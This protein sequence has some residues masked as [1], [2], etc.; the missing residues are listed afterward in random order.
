[1]ETSGKKKLKVL[2]LED[3]TVLAEELKLSVEELGL[4]ATD[5]VKSYDEAIESVKNNPPDL[6]LCDI[7]IRGQIDGVDT[8]R[9]IRNIKEIPIIFT[10]AYLESQYVMQA[11]EMDAVNYLSKPVKPEELKKY[12]DKAIQEINNHK[13]TAGT[14]THFNLKYGRNSHSIKIDDLYLVEGAG[15]GSVILLQHKFILCPAMVLSKTLEELEHPHI[16]RINRSTAINIA[17]VESYEKRGVTINTGDIK[18]KDYQTIERKSTNSIRVNK[19]VQDYY[20]LTDS[21]RDRFEQAMG[22][23]GSL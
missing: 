15:A 9:A 23:L 8:A 19:K 10:T 1:M 4:Q 20:T 11:F 16:V 22:S 14:K 7:K 21:Y 12:I 2:I 13:P 17:K 18:Y 5:L 6:A 3:E